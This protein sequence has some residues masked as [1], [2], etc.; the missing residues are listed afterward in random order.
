[1]ARP[2]R[3]V[4]RATYCS[5]HTWHGSAFELGLEYRPTAEDQLFLRA[6]E[7]LWRYPGL[8]GPWPRREE[9]GNSIQITPDVP[10]R[11]SMLWLYGL[12]ELKDGRE[13][14]CSSFMLRQNDASDSLSLCLP[15]GMLGRLFPV[16]HNPMGVKGNPW[17]RD[18]EDLL[19]D[20]AAWVYG[21][22][23]FE[24]AVLG[25][26]AAA[27][28]PDAAKLTRE[29]L[30]HGGYILPDVLWRHLDPAVEARPLS[31]GLRHVPLNY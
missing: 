23:P 8:T 22:A 16:S 1:M 5:P 7:Q 11:D 9:Y 12:L 21:A 17:L 10:P 27:L 30:S 25:E 20:I 24:L 19:A 2:E 3:P 14:A 31:H 28:G 26:E 13:A 6:A 29:L 4:D 18:I 15:S